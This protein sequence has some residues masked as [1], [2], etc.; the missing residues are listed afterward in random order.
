LSQISGSKIL[1]TGGAGFVGSHIVDLLVKEKAQKIIVLDNFIRGSRENLSWALENGD[2][3]IIEGDVRDKN[4]VND[5]IK[6][7]DFIFHQAALRITQCA[8]MPQEGFEVLFTGTFNVLDAARKSKVEKIVSASSASVYGE[9]TYLPIDEKHP[10][11]NSTL[12]GAGK[13]ATEQIHRAFYDMFGLDYICLRY[14]NVYGPRMDVFGV[15]TE[16]MIK[17]LDRIDEG[18]SPIIFGD[19]KTSMDFIYVKDVAK[20]NI[21]AL[22][23]DVTNEIFNVGSGRETSLNELVQLLI[24]LK[25]SSLGIEYKSPRK[26]NPVSRRKAC[27]DKARKSLGFTSETHLEAGLKELINWYSEI[28]NKKDRSKI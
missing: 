26:V 15:Y 7:I 14:F 13:I 22:R 6:G 3:E 16:V 24:N 5:I 4:L 20:S 28:K 21:L 2:V 19:G 8:E 27:I 10:F 1:I 18:K 12:Y 11:N 9:P 17:W 25:Q 23:S